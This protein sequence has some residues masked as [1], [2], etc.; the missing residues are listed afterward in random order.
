MPDS[1]NGGRVDASGQEQ[2]G[3]HVGAEM[4]VDGICE[5]DPSSSWRIA[6]ASGP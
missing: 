4:Q 6:D 1:S 5:C 2:C 3:G